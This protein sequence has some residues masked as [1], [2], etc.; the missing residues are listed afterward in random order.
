MSLPEFDVTDQKVLVVGAGRGIGKGIALA[1]AEAGADIAVTA[2]SSSGV[3]QVAK[4]IQEMGRAAFPVT[5]DATKA[6]DMDRI[7]QETLDKF[8]H[9]DTIVNCV[10][11]AIRKPVVTLPGSSSIGMTE[12]EWHFIVDINLTEAYQGCHAIGPHMLERRQGSVINI[13]GWAAFRGRPESAAY[14]AAKAGIMRFT[15]C[16]AQEW[17]PFGI[18]A[19]AIAPGSF[20]DPDQMS[21]EAYQQ[22]QDAAKGQIPLGRTG[23][24][25]EIGYL[26]VFLSSPAAAY[27]TGQTWAVDGGISIKHP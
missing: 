10:G 22:R 19:N 16:L 5:G 8:G 17:A 23:H 21:E 12:E 7:V 18:R 1:F 4:E 24:L 6:A 2:L 9:V 20:P 14:D 3:N 13:T 27:V 25:K 15:E 26:S 11:D